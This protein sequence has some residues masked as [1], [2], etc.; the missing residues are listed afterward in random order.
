MSTTNQQMEVLISAEAEAVKADEARYGLSQFQL[1]WRK[2]KRSKAAIIAG[3][4]VILLYLTALFANFLAPYGGDQRN[5]DFLYVPP[6]GLRFDFS[7]GFYVNELVKKID[8]DT[9]LTTFTANPD[10]KISVQF[11]VHNQP[12]KLFGFID[13]DVHLIGL[14]DKNQPIYLLGSDRQGRDVL[15]RILLGSQMSLTIGL[16]GVFISLIIGSVMGTVSGFYGGWVDNFIQRLIEVIRSFPSVPLWMALSAAL[17]QHWPPQQVYFAI[18]IILSFIGWTWLAR[19]LRG[20]VLALREEEFVNASILSGASDRWVVFRHL[21]PAVL[22]HIIV[23]STLA[24]PGMILAESTLSFLNLGLR[25]PLISWGVLL[26]EAQ[27]LETIRHFPWLLFPAAA[28]A[29]T[30]LAFN[31]FG[32]GLRDAADPYS[33]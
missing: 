23:I 15:S 11:F 4:V 14:S 3:I 32:D 28:I 13:T 5:T 7:T 9:L 12:Y 25:P 6:M 1:M 24:M 33:M 20:K 21:I 10:K 31:F 26:N 16:V 17:P 18:T 29:I 2:F 30:V 8:L 27:N 22:G 19:Q